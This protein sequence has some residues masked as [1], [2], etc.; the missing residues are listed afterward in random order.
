MIIEK[1]VKV[2]ERGQIVIPKE[3][4][5]NEGIEP[6]DHLQV[7]DVGGELIIK[8][9]NREKAPEEKIHELLIKAKFTERDWQEMLKERNK[10]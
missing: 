3:M 1:Y 4:R 8:I 5:E 10:E 7:L 2:G 9:K 6:E